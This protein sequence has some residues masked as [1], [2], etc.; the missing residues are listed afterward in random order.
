MDQKRLQKL[1]SNLWS[2]SASTQ[3]VSDVYIIKGNPEVDTGN[4]H[5]YAS[6]YEDVAKVV[7]E[8]GFT[9]SFDDGLGGTLPPGGKL[10]IGHSRGG[11]RLRFAPKEV[12]TLK[13][14]DF[15]PAEAKEKQRLAY[16]QLFKT[17]GYKNIADVP[18]HLRPQPGPEH[19]TLNEEAKAAIVTKLRELRKVRVTSRLRSLL[20]R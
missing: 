20:G 19:Y 18:L 13:L 12:A 9:Y 11:D 4:A 2:K 1:L 10:W 7:G 17:Q 6:F 8:N 14:D 15:E 3:P 5:N 16:E